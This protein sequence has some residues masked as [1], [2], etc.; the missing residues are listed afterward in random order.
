MRKT[1]LTTALLTLALAGVAQADDSTT[2]TP[3]PKQTAQKL[4]RAERGTTAETK[5]AFAQKYGTNKNKKNAFGKCVSK[6]T[7][8]QRKQHDTAT[9][10][11]AEISAAKA[12]ATERGTTDATQTAFAAK[13]GTNTNKNNAFGKCVSQKAAAKL[14]DQAKADDD[15]TSDDAPKPESVHS[16]N[17]HS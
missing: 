13:Y 4:C 5:A 8:A 12:C 10:D 15:T 17:P 3:S 7:A 14:H 16:G 11:A 6:T 1:A 9:E 2:T